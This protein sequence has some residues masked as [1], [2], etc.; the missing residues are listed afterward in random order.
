MKSITI[1][2]ILRTTNLKN[3][4]QTRVATQILSGWQSLGCD[5]QG[6]RRPGASDLDSLD[7]FED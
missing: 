3:P 5:T 2:V 4:L 7:Q 1:I 6:V